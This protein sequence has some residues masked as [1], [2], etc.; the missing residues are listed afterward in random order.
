MARFG[1][2]GQISG[3]NLKNDLYHTFNNFVFL[4][5][6]LFNVWGFK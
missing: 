4:H 1:A 6:Y 3:K 5:S 2:D